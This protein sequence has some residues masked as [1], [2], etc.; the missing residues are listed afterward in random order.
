ML[1]DTVEQAL[2]TLG[3]TSERVSRWLGHPCNCPERVEKLNR[4]HRWAV[5]VVGGR[6]LNAREYLEQIIGDE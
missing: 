3:I 1:G 6:L 2:T 4:L 5:R